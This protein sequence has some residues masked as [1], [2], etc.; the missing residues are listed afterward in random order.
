MGGGLARDEEQGERGGEGIDRMR[1]EKRERA[2]TKW[3]SADAWFQRVGEPADEV[4]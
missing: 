2:N 4:G 3:S 1:G